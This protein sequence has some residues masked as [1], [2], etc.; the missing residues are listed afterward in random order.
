[1]F[2]CVVVYQ[3]ES[4]LLAANAI[5]W[6]HAERLHRIQLILSLLVAAL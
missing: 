1:M 3:G 2:K 5:A 4:N 6:A